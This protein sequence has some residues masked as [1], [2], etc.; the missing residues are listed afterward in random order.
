MNKRKIVFA[1]ISLCLL[2]CPLVIFGDGVYL[3]PAYINGTITL[4]GYQYSDVVSSAYVYANSTGGFTANV[5]VQSN[6][7]YSLTVNAPE[8]GTEREYTI[9]ARIYLKSGAQFEP[10]LQKKIAVAKGN[11]YTQNFSWDLATLNV[12]GSFTNDDWTTLSPFYQNSSPYL[13][14]YI[15]ASQTG[16]HSFLIPAN[17]PFT[18]TWGNAYPKDTTKYNQLSLDK[19]EFTAS[20]G[21]TVSLT[22]TGTFPEKPVMPAGT[23]SGNISY[24]PLPEGKLNNHYVYSSNSISVNQDGPFRI[25]NEPAGTNKWVY[26]YSYFNNG[27]QLY[28]PYYF[29]NPSDTYGR[30]NLSPGGETVLNITANPVLVKGHLILT[31]TKSLSETINSPYIYANGSSNTKAYGGSAYDYA[32]NKNTGEYRLYLTEG[33]WNVGYYI[34][35]LYFQNNSSNPAEYYY[36]Y[37][38]YYDYTRTETFNSQMILTG[39]QVIE[40]N[41]ITIPTGTVTIEYSSDDGA[42]VSSPRIDGTMYNSDGSGRTLNYCYVYGYGSS[43]PVQVARATFVGA[44]GTYTVNTTAVVNGSTVTFAPR[45]VIVIEGVH[46]VIQINGPT[47]TLNSPAAELYTYD[48]SLTVQGT[49]TDDKEVTGIAIN[50]QSVAFQSTNNPND[51]R[52]VGFNT[53]IPLANGPNK[54]Q[55]T[56]TNSFGKTASDTRYVYKD[57]GPPALT[58]T[59]ANGTTT[60]ASIITLIGKATDDNQITKI[61]VNG[62]SLD[63]ISTNNPHDPNE[64]TFSKVYTLDQGANKFT[65]IA[66]DNC[67]RSATVMNIITQVE[68]DTV[69]PVFGTVQNL[70][71]EQ[72]TPQ[73]TAYQLPKPVV[74]D[75]ADP[76]PMVTGNAPAVF[77]AGVTTVTW[78]ATDASG[79]TAT[80]AQTVTVVD[81]TPPSITA[82]ANLTIEYTGVPVFMD[83]LG[84]PIVA[85]A[86]D[87]APQ[88][89]VSGVPGSF[90][91]G[92]TE[93][94]WKATDKSGNSASAIQRVWANDTIAPVTT[95]TAGK[96]QASKDGKLYITSNTFLNIAAT[97]SG[98][99]VASVYYNPGSGSVRYENPITLPA[100]GDYHLQYYAADVAGNAETPNVIS[101]TVDNNGPAIGVA[102]IEAGT[103]YRKPV[104]PVITINDPILDTYTVTLN[105]APY[106]SGTAI[107]KDGQ[108]TLRVSATDLLGNA[109]SYSVSFTMKQVELPG[110]Y[111]L[112]SHK[113]KVYWQ[114]IGGAA[115][116][117]IYLNGHKVNNGHHH[118]CHHKYFCYH[119]YHHLC[120]TLVKGTSDVILEIHDKN[121]VEVKAVNPSGIEFATA[122]KFTI[123][124]AQTLT[125]IWKGFWDRC[126]KDKD[127][128][129][130]PA[131]TYTVYG[132]SPFHK[133]VMAYYA[134]IDENGYRTAWIPIGPVAQD[135]KNQ[136]T[137]KVPVTG[138]T[139]GKFVAL[140]VTGWDTKQ[141]REEENGLTVFIPEK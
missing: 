71:L 31:G 95:V 29:I 69:S 103:A 14:F 102:G 97:D 77:P 72:T 127:K 73:G 30:I 125:L 88:V 16:T 36:T 136:F 100:T 56:A 123:Y 126:W 98:S 39:G 4:N 2:L 55:V 48:S 120:N 80:V 115:G 94:I 40:G 43:T 129:S 124:Q 113:V 53:N 41:D 44:P 68:Q 63:F 35:N 15:S 27:Q 111:F 91:L 64:V 130:N 122:A 116:Y 109:S 121:L 8:D 106:Q 51:P 67:K 49:A 114:A 32:I 24:G 7:T 50:G 86:A 85:D 110:Y 90:P 66:T 33:S 93:I 131:D 28:W 128:P 75:N 84:S 1:L 60:A 70:T 140:R 87:P 105:G 74:T 11:T 3:F 23:I 13:Y 10:G 112:D 101:V 6:G 141:N 78:I 132:V 46:T 42:L 138:E 25:E 81:T 96:P 37:F 65:V 133:N 34:S 107:D 92:V 57:N 82:P 99:G 79:N 17:I 104:T 12:N 139:K 134:V 38:N 26:A 117:N 119:Q 89:T 54:I 20:A 135:R 22:W 61:T 58:V 76:A 52:E 5:N 118:D 62:L 19:K 59:P 47:L 9:Y 83:I 137:F 21:E 108:Y 45:K 18:W